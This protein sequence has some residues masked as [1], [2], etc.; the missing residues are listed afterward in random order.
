MLEASV[1]VLSMR[2]AWNSYWRGKPVEVISYFMHIAAS[3]VHTNPWQSSCNL[4]CNKGMALMYERSHG[5]GHH[6]CDTQR[7]REPDGN[8]AAE[9]LL[10]GSLC[11]PCVRSNGAGALQSGRRE[12]KRQRDSQLPLARRAKR[13]ANWKKAESVS[14][15]AEF[16]SSW[17]CDWAHESGGGWAGPRVAKSLSHPSLHRHRNPSKGS[18]EMDR[19][20]ISKFL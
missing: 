4:P 12:R 13:R 6:C 3:N 14:P 7:R 18:G 10:Y 9:R 2:L 20:E 19:L 5:H 11:L 8:S 15:A 16:P 17:S 1:D